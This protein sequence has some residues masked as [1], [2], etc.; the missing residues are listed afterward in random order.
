[1]AWFGTYPQIDFKADDGHS[2]IES[3]ATLKNSDDMKSQFI[4]VSSIAAREGT[5]SGNQLVPGKRA[6][7]EALQVNLIDPEHKNDCKVK[8]VVSIPH[9][10]SP[11]LNPSS[12]PLK[13]YFENKCALAALN[14]SFQI[15]GTKLET[16]SVK[17]RSVFFEGDR[18]TVNVEPTRY[19]VNL[20]IQKGRDQ[21]GPVQT[22][23]RF[24]ARATSG[25][26][27]VVLKK[28]SKEGWIELK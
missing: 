1:M 8:S 5:Y 9:A 4:F 20:E 21:V 10:K 18:K 28:E 14:E 25:G 13:P 19:W 26:G 15:V 12:K 24:L 11:I 3:M 27:C 16:N 17:V 7:V 2:N 22:T 6:G 23:F